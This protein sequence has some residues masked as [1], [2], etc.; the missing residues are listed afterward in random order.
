MYERQRDIK[1]DATVVLLKNAIAL[2]DTQYQKDKAKL[3]IASQE[4]KDALKAKYLKDLQ[5]YS[6]KNQEVIM[7][8]NED[9][10]KNMREARKIVTDI[11]ANKDRPPQ[12]SG[13]EF[14]CPNDCSAN[15]NCDFRNG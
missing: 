11:V 6:E 12:L 4:V 13:V 14:S 7:R 15:G 8:I 9:Y 2:L 1:L 10:S 3:K 5:T